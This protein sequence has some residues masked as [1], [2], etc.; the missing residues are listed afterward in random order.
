[1]AISA[2][3]LTYVREQLSALT[4]VTSRR[5][6]GGVGLYAEGVFFGLIANDVLYFKVGDGNRCDYE[7]RGMSPFRPHPGKPHVSLSYYE[8]PSEVLEDRD[9]CGLWARRS[10]AV[11]SVTTKKAR[12]LAPSPKRSTRQKKTS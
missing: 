2:D 3:F 7:A 10:V 4:D 5:M 6:F 1:M 8:V 11:A 9:E 12:S